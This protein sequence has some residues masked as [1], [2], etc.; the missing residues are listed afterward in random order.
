MIY[1]NIAEYEEG[2]SILA[3]QTILDLHKEIERLNNRLK[4]SNN[5]CNYLRN[6]IDKAIFFI[7]NQELHKSKDTTGAITMK[8]REL[9]DILM[10]SDKEW[11]KN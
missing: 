5:T 7:K 4:T 9:I 11:I 2:D 6:T 1:S 3:K 10:G 8:E